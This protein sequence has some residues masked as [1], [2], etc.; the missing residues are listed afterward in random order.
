ME[1]TPCVNLPPPPSPPAICNDRSAPSPSMHPPPLLTRVRMYSITAFSPPPPY[2]KLESLPQLI[3]STF[4]Y[5]YL[6]TWLVDCLKQRPL[7]IIAE[8]VESD[9]LATLI[10]NKIQDG[11]KVITEDLGMNLEKVE[12]NM[13][14]SCK[15]VT[16]SKDDTVILDGFG[17]KKAIEERC[18][19]LRASIEESTSDYDKEKLQERLAKLSGGV[20]VL[21]MVDSREEIGLGL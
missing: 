14:G 11:I 12:L 1:A 17:D 2:P 10:L 13:F 3:S 20:A 18:E 6:L 8:D 16:V 19:L 9:A 15:K 21:K 4:I 5:A 7:L